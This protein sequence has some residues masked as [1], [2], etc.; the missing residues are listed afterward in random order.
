MNQ[1]KGIMMQDSGAV[2]ENGFLKGNRSTRNQ[3][4][5]I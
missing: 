5:S 3:K 4:L 1:G 2:F